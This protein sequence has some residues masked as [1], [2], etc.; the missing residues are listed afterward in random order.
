MDVLK[1]DSFLTVCPKNSIAIKLYENIGY[2]FDKLAKGYYRESEDRI[3]AVRKFKTN[4][5]AE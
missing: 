3:V 1:Q 4:N 2:E 5:Y